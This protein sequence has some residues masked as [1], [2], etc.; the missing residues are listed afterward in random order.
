MRM[1]SS[2]E[3][4]VCMTNT[5]IRSFDDWYTEIQTKLRFEDRCPILIT[6]KGV[7]IDSLN[8]SQEIRFNLK[9]EKKIQKVFSHIYKKK[10][11][12][13]N[14]IQLINITGLNEYFLFNINIT[15]NYDNQSLVTA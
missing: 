1:H 5:T 9:L 7:S 8:D 15:E 3:H 10:S 4:Y 2:M 6:P 11:F 12:E 14:P 13:F